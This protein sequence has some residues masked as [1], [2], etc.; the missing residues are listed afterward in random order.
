V[1]VAAD[2]NNKTKSIRIMKYAID[3]TYGRATNTRT[4]NRC[5]QYYKFDTA[6]QRDAW[7]NAR[8]TEYTTQ[9]GFREAIQ[10]SDSEL[11]KLL[12]SDAKETQ[13]GGHQSVVDGSAWADSLTA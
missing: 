12:R 2:A 1:S 7:V 8:P 11:R 3:W 5:G 4:G 6:A 9:A 13:W 10:S